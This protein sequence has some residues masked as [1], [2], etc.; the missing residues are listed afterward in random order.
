[1]TTIDP[2]ISNMQRAV[3]DGLHAHWGRLLFQGVIMIIL[4]AVAFAAPTIATIAV[5]IF[6]G[7][8][9]LLSGLVGLTALFSV[10][11]VPAFVWTLFTAALSVVGGAMLI[12]KPAEGVI[13]LTLMLTAFFIVEGI[14]HMAAS[15]TYRDLLP[16]SWGWVFL[17]GFSDLAL[18]AIIIW[19]WPL[20]LGWFLGLLVGINLVTSGLAFVM[21][22]VAGRNIGGDP[23]SASR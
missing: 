22:A 8:L 17:S 16:S 2:N 19:G 20:S 23:A 3:R 5:D 21:A 11:G 13:S 15:F 1:M 14:F 7:W 10:R 6:V 18:A 4:G 9:F 12:W